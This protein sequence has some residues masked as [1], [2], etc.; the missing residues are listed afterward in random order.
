MFYF[1]LKFFNK[2]NVL[3]EIKKKE[4]VRVVIEVIIESKSFTFSLFFNMIFNFFNFF[5]FF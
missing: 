1:N 5:N 2:F 3:K 4:I